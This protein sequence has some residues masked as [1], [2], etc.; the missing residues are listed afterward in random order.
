MPEGAR[1][2]VLYVRKSTD[3]EDKQIL[4]IPAQLKELREFAVRTG[5]AID[6]ELEEACSAREPGRPVF[7]KLLEHRPV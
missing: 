2:C 1:H 4:S 5:L 7:S 6:G 3:R